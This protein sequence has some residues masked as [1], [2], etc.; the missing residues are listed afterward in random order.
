[1]EKTFTEK[2][3]Y[4]IIIEGDYSC[5][6]MVEEEL[7]TCAEDLHDCVWNYVAENISDHYPPKMTLTNFTIIEEN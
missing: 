1:M 4:R 3:H 5:C 6:N 7:D 2:V